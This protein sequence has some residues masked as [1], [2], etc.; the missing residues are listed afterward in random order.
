MTRTARLLCGISA[1]AM[2]A[3]VWGVAHASAPAT[4]GMS[5]GS[6]AIAVQAPRTSDPLIEVMLRSQGQLTPQSVAAFLPAAVGPVTPERAQAMPEIMRNVR[7]LGVGKDVEAAALQT[8]VNL[9]SSAAGNTLDNE[10]AAKLKLQ[11]SDQVTP[12]IQLAKVQN[13]NGTGKASD[14]GKEH[15]NNKGHGNGTYTN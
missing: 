14:N 13:N 9:I 5:Q 3:G 1:L 4:E 2:S 7:A 12:L 10:A 11:M 15:N 8:L 6:A